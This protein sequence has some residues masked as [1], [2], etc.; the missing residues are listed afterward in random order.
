MY[1]TR[2][3][4]VD[5]DVN[6]SNLVGI[7]LQRTGLYDVKVENRS[8]QALTVARDF[9]PQLVLLDVDMPGMDGGDI[10]AQLRADA[11]LKS[12]P[13][14]FF[15]SLVGQSESGDGLV[16]LGGDHFLAKHVKP[17]VLVRCIAE[18]LAGTSQL[19]A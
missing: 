10:A 8:S 9:R 11:A 16:K 15:T 12:V 4:I 13:I 2:I 3:L 5:D 6:L 7:I 17:A 1:K 18:R 14:I 19:A